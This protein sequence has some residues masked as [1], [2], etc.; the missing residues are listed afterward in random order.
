MWR[1]KKSGQTQLD[2]SFVAKLQK[3]K[4]GEGNLVDHILPCN[5]VFMTVADA[6]INR[7]A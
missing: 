5:P 2:H 3:V 6:N 7:A 4:Q 1:E